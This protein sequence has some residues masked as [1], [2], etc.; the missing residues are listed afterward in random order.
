MK[1]AIKIA[2]LFLFIGIYNPVISN[3]NSEEITPKSKL[4]TERLEQ[5]KIDSKGN[6]YVICKRYPKFDQLLQFKNNDWVQI[7]P[8][9][10][11]IDQLF[12]DQIDQV[13]LKARKDKSYAQLYQMNN[14]KWIE[15]PKVSAESFFCS[16]CYTPNNEIIA[17]G[18]IKENGKNKFFLV[19]NVNNQWTPI[20]Y[21]FNDP[22]LQNLAED[23]CADITS[24]RKGGFFTCHFVYNKGNSRSY[25][26]HYTNGKWSLLDTTKF[27]FYSTVRD[28]G[29]D[30]KGNLYVAGSYADDTK[31]RCVVKW[32]NNEWKIINKQQDAIEALVINASD[33]VFIA[34][35][36]G[37]Y[38]KYQIL[39]INDESA[40]EYAYSDKYSNDLA[41]FN[42][43]A[44]VITYDSKIYKIKAGD[45]A[46]FKPLYT[47]S[48]TISSSTNS[49][50]TNS[51]NTGVKSNK[52]AIDAMDEAWKNL[53][54]AASDY[55]KAKG[56][57]VKEA[58]TDAPKISVLAMAKLLKGKDVNAVISLAKAAG[59]TKFNDRKITSSPWGSMSQKD[60]CTEY[61]SVE[62]I[63]IAEGLAEALKIN[64]Y[65][66]GKINIFYPFH[67]YDM[68]SVKK[69]LLA[70]GFKMEFEGKYTNYEIGASINFPRSTGYSFPF[71]VIY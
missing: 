16:A 21:R 17:P 70:A 13:Y 11:F 58:T 26:G 63:K 68:E 69:E 56:I 7:G 59:V 54:S 2:F 6:M 71:I 27:T 34:G 40:T 44:Y 37:S 14:Y 61:E 67:W 25:F 47:P 48:S 57:K 51:S 31:S 42:N 49:T 46:E 35:S 24:D 55:S 12:I 52:S 1:T 36:F 45:F 23:R 10:V 50:S 22:F 29:V 5:L 33:E 62:K 41:V 38:P 60:S 8:E 32:S 9:D 15:M 39:K 65:K 18:F 30:S 3:E 4:T 66:N 28:M 20:E 64:H 53:A 43:F 19:K